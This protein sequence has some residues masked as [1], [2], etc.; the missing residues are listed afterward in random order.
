ME[1]VTTA[2]KDQRDRLFQDLRKNGNEL[3]RQVVKFSGFEPVMVMDTAEYNV[4]QLIDIIVYTKDGTR[5]ATELDKEKN[6]QFR[7]RF[8]STWSVAYPKE[9]M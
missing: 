5:Q 1:V 8:R 3:E 6:K 4:G 9:A 7:P 2:D